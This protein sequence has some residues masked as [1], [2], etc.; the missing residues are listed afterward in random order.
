MYNPLKYAWIEEERRF[1]LGSNPLESTPA[2][3]FNRIIDRYITGTRLRLRRIES[4]SGEVLVEIEAQSG[5]E[6]SSLPVPEFATREVTGDQMFSGGK[7]V[8]L[9]K[10]DFQSWMATW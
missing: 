10:T 4:P 2:E 5:V 7:L 1:L 9:L 3:S 6:I 8:E